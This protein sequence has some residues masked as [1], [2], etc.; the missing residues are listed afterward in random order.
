[1]SSAVAM[2]SKTPRG[3]DPSDEAAVG[4]SGCRGGISFIV[5]PCSVSTLWPWAVSAVRAGGGVREASTGTGGGG[6]GGRRVPGTED[7]GM[8]MPIRRDF[9]APHPPVGGWAVEEDAAPGSS[10]SG[11][12][13]GR[14]GGGRLA[15]AGGG[16]HLPGPV[17]LCDEPRPPLTGWGTEGGV[18]GL[19]G[20]EGSGGVTS[21]GNGSIGWPGEGSR[22]RD[23]GERL[24]C[25]WCRRLKRRPR[26]I[27]HGR[28]SCHW[29]SLRS[30]RG[31]ERGWGGSR[32]L[33]LAVPG[34]T[35]VY[36]SIGAWLLR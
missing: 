2:E 27:G 23:R 26:G 6:V 22:C 30:R 4:R 9:G 15:A 14:G 35:P 17:A 31:V 1:M 11:R 8:G 21:L 3:M 33:R 32:R 16:L 10:T 18:G 36:A 5:A 7:I 28:R 12:S 29:G 20:G 24:S 19:G 34:V 25:S 13:G